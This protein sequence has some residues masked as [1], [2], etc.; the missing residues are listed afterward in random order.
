MSFEEQM[1]NIYPKENSIPAEYRIKEI[2]QKEYL[3]DGEIRTWNGPQQEVLSPIYLQGDKGLYPKKLG[4][5]PLLT[6]KEAM[7]ALDSA[8]KAYNNGCGEWPTMTVEK[9]IKCIESFAYK[10]K[11]KRTEVV[12]LLM[13]EIC[14]NYADS[15]KEFDRT[16]EYILD[17][18]NALKELDRA[19]SRFIIEQGIIGQIR[20]A[21]LGV[22]LCMGPFNYPLN[23]TFTTLIPALIMGNTTIFKPAKFGTL[24]FQPL[25]QAFRESFPKGVVNTL[26]GEGK[27]VIPPIMSSGHI[28]VFAFIGSASV[29]NTL[30]KQHPKPN[31]LRRVLGLGAKNP[32]IILDDADIDLTVKECLLGT[33]SYNGQRCTALKILFV[34]KKIADQFLEKYCAAV[35]KLKMGMPWESG[36]DITPLP[37][38]HKTDHMLELIQEAIAKGAKIINPNGSRS[39][40]TIMFPAVVYPVTEK[41]KLYT[42]EQFGPVVPVVPFESIETPIQ[43]I[44]HSNVGQQA[45]IF[46]K[47]PDMIGKLIDPLVNQVCRLNI[48]SQCQRGPDSFPFTGKKDS[49]EGTLSISDA[50]RVFSIRTIVAA[51]AEEANKEILTNITRGRKSNFLNT[52]YIL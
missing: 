52:D 19:S 24:L 16:L 41:M 6:G 18:V 40:K 14:K 5:Y 37:E 27:V 22:V 46:G 50:L 49:A 3:M 47:N 15:C 2:F 26:Y 29:A 45:S 33:L 20:R 23:E 12:N 11:E 7:E 30:E 48:N 51:K 31:R 21:P 42:V 4:S 34:Q 39:N 43:Y 38:S 1:N 35:S 44:I 10:I 17:T 28:D 13:W 25:L 8:Q 32:G 36:V 9:R